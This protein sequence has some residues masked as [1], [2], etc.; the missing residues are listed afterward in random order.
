MSPPSRSRASAGAP[1][2][3]RAPIPAPIFAALGDQTRLALVAKLCAGPARSI[4]ELAGDFAL[5]RQAITKHLRVL[6]HAGIVHS[7]RRGRESR[8]HFDPRPIDQ[9][10]Q[11]L[12]LVS[13]HW[14]Q[15]LLRLK[16]L[17]EG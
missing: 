13:E 7:R 10:R 2:R 1:R 8:F 3:A 14:D 6:E 15:A 17:V 12:D 9:V 4:S 16:S 11:Y 5:T